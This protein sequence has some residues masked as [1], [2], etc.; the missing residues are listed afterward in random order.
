M[1]RKTF[2]LA[3]QK[4]TLVIPQEVTEYLNRCQGAVEVSLTIQSSDPATF[5]PSSSSENSETNFQTAWNCWFAEVDQLE[6]SPS[7][8]EPDEYGK[9]LIEKY[10]K[11]GLEL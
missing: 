7:Q 2:R 8:S 5:P 11:Q 10:R 1:S 4:D 9:S 3:F 6:P